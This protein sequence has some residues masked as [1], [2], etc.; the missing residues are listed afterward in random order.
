MSVLGRRLFLGALTPPHCWPVLSGSPY[1]FQWPEKALRHRLATLSS[2]RSLYVGMGAKGRW[3]DPSNV[4][5]QCQ[6]S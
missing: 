5:Y 1:G 6:G 3:W 4:C 2:R